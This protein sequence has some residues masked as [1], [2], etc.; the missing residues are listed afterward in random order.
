MVNI[1]RDEFAKQIFADNLASTGIGPSTNI[2]SSH[3][4]PIPIKSLD[5]MSDELGVSERH[6]AN[7]IDTDSI[8]HKA[9]CIRVNI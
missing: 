4:S 5:E 1:S 8:P 3:V 6:V 7:A 2:V 9:I